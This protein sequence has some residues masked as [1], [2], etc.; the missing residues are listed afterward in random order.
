MRA[1]K[2][3]QRLASY[4]QEFREVSQAVTM[5]SRGRCEGGVPGVCQRQAVHVHHRKLRK[6]GGEN[7]LENCIHLCE[8]CHT[9]AHGHP[10][11]AKELG[12]L[13][14][15]WQDPAQIE[16]DVSRYSEHEQG[17]NCA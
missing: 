14:S 6:Q 1:H 9:W 4:N 10:L 3:T 2:T 12:L 15:P 13:V 11:L 16:V 5:R 17:Q 7:S 8:A